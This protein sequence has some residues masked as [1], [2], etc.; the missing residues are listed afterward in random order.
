MAKRPVPNIKP[1]RGSTRCIWNS[2]TNRYHKQA[3]SGNS[4]L[5]WKFVAGE[6]DPKKD[7]KQ[8]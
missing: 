2:R 7:N 6:C 1:T 4:R 5:P 8:R 3:A